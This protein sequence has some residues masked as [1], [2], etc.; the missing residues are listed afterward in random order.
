[1][2]FSISGQYPR[3]SRRDQ[4]LGLG[5]I[6]RQRR[7]RWARRADHPDRLGARFS[8]VTIHRTLHSAKDHA[9][10]PPVPARV[11][12][13]RS[14]RRLGVCYLL[15]RFFC[16]KCR[17]AP[18]SPS[19]WPQALPRRSDEL[20]S[21]RIRLLLCQTFNLSCPLVQPAGG[22]CVRPAWIDLRRGSLVVHPAA[23]FH[24]GWISKAVQK[25]V[26]PKHY[27]HG[28]DRPDDGRAHS[29]LRPFLHRR[30]WLFR[31]SGHPRP[32]DNGG[33][34]TCAAICAEIACHD[35]QPRLWGVGRD[36]LSLALPWRYAGRRFRGRNQ[37]AP[38]SFR[39]DALLRRPSSEWR[40]SS[41]QE[42]AV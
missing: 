31:H 29:R 32:Q 7:R 40:L 11:S 21:A 42:R 39:T 13:Q 15:L 28:G 37:F 23:R 20:L 17:T 3:H 2:R 14:T 26:R 27:G 22:D 24:G 10:C 6:D 34:P 36:L 38:P 4:S 35:H 25:R 16:Q 41:A 33:R 12:P 30:G 1:M 9:Y 18:F 5:N 8:V 19:S